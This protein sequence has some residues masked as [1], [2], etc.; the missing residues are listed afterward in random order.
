MLM[1]LPSGVCETSEKT[2]VMEVLHDSGLDTYLGY[3]ANC[4]SCNVDYTTCMS[5]WFPYDLSMG[6]MS[7]ALSHSASSTSR[8]EA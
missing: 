2:G 5:S 1:S 4:C 8:R 3:M 6:E 7:D